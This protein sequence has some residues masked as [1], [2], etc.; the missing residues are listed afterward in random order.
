MTA[1]GTA[2]SSEESVCFR[3]SALVVLASEVAAPAAEDL[4]ASALA[5]PALEDAAPAAEDLR[6]A[7][8]AVPV[9]EDA[10]PVASSSPPSRPLRPPCSKRCESKIPVIHRFWV[11][12]KMRREPHVA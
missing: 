11:D 7:A 4:R 3:A 2:E 8:L 10:V 5:V 6:A 12:P 9:L 1:E